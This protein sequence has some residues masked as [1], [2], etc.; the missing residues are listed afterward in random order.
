[1]PEVTVSILTYN[2]LGPVKAC[3]ASILR[4]GE[5]VKFILT[6][7]GNKEVANYFNEF[8][9]VHPNVTVIE[10]ATNEGFWKPNNHALTL[11]DTKYFCMVNDDITVTFGWLNIL[12]KPLQQHERSVFCAPDSGCTALRWDFHGTY[13]PKEYCE[14]ALLLCN[15]EIIKKHGLFEPLP[16]LAYGEDSH[17]SLRFREMGYNLHWVPMMLT[18][19]RGA[20]SR[21]VQEV[22][23]WQEEN[24][25]YLRKRWDYYLARRTFDYPIIFKRTGAFGDVLLVTPV[26][27]EMKR[28]RPL[29]KIYVETDCVEVFAN[30][31][32]VEKAAQRIN[33]LPQEIRIDLNGSYENEPM[34]NFVRTYAKHAG[35]TVTSDQTEL[36]VPRSMREWARGLTNGN[37]WIGINTGPTWESKTLP[38]AKWEELLAKLRADGFKILAVGSGGQVGRTGPK[39]EMDMRNQTT[40]PQLAALIAE[41]VIFICVD[42][43]PLHVAQA[44][45]TPIVPLFGVTLPGPILTSGSKAVP[46]VSDPSHPG[47]GLRHKT[48]GRTFTPS[49]QN[50]MDTIT[51]EQVYAAASKLLESCLDPVF[52]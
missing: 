29:S 11:C 20:T 15:T 3:L 39:V 30:N 36:Y 48:A 52:D 22:H 5:D 46:V 7:N 47:S 40:I 37:R 32:L 25:A 41:C 4:G 50:P 12:K 23:K 19:L 18:H 26:I 34:E 51:A 2:Q 9:M 21:H 43:F 38:D 17:A 10:N 42:S 28:Q 49:P 33:P 45:G 27:R 8:S 35:I 31:P 44:V 24:H 14:G 1:M 16:G 13:G 6:S